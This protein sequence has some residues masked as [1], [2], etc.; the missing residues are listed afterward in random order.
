MTQIFSSNR[1]IV[2]VNKRIFVFFYSS[3]VF[4]EIAQILLKRN[5]SNE[6]LV[7]KQNLPFS[8]LSEYPASSIFGAINV[9]ASR[10]NAIRQNGKSVRMSLGV[11]RRVVAA[12]IKAQSAR[13]PVRSGPRAHFA[14]AARFRKISFGSVRPCG[15][16]PFHRRATLPSS[17]PLPAHPQ[18][19]LSVSLPERR[20][21]H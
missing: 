13:A 21:R 17:R 5:R 7:E 1:T 12:I 9:K 14:T 18:P 19:S 10:S 20:S 2:H 11:A 4:I 3:A 15:F 6:S 8:S 16:L